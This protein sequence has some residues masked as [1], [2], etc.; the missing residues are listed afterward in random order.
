MQ[1]RDWAIQAFNLAGY[2]GGNAI[3]T[4]E[5]QGTIETLGGTLAAKWLQS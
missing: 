1:T 2:A 4:P 3:V 5:D